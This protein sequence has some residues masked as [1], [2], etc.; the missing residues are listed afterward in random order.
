[1]TVEELI[2]REQI[3]HTLARYNRA[4]D[5]NNADEFAACFTEDCVFDATVAQLRGRES[6]RQWKAASTVFSHGKS[7]AVATFRVHHISSIH[8]ELVA[9]DR[10]R[11]RTCWLVITD[12]GP[13]HSGVYYDEFRRE[14]NQWLIAKR[15]VDC[16]W[17]AENSFI[18]PSVVGR[19]S[20]GQNAG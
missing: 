18:S 17:R 14:G 13:D 1:M 7:G 8:I 5:E 15:V 2:S 20:T 6:I 9:P 3:R 10:V 4:G 12:I 19:R 16:L 11:T